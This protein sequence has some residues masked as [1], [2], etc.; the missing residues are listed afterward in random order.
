MI[1]LV[2]NNQSLFETDAYSKISIDDAIDILKPHDL[3]EY[4]SETQGL[5]VYTKKLLCSQYGIK[6]TQIVIDHTTIPVEKMKPI[7]EDK[8]KTLLGWNISFDLRFIYHHRIVPYNVWDGM[9]AEQLLY[10]GYPVGLHGYSL[11]EAA[12]HYLGIDID[13]SVRGQIVTQGLTIPVIKYAAGD[14]TY[15]RDIKEKQDIEL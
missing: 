1:Y 2:S 13:K 15:L 10:L 8:D 12:N 6:G 9:I 5:D 3:I 4:D 14:V 11:K 7:L